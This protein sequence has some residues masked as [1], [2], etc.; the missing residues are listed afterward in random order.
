MKLQ[1]EG[2]VRMIGISNTYDVKMLDA[3]QKARKV[4][5]VQNRWAGYE[6]NKLDMHLQL[7]NYCRQ[8]IM[9][10]SVLTVTGSPSLA[11]LKTPAIARLTEGNSLTPA[12]AVLR[13]AQE[14]GVVIIDNMI[15]RTGSGPALVI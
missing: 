13:H 14:R 6:G 8:K 11:N 7:F 10:Q 15:D 2:K 4:Q 3:L 5:V 1:D 12:K 9:Y